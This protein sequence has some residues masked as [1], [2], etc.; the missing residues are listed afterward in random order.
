ME[1]NN[2]FVEV[3]AGVPSPGDRVKTP[4]GMGTVLYGYQSKSNPSRAGSYMV[5]LDSSNPHS[6]FPNT[7]YAVKELEIVFPEDISE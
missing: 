6:V 2:I 5:R 7:M 4:G 3:I 1:M